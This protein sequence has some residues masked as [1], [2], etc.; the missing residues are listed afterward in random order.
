MA[1]SSVPSARNCN[2]AAYRGTSHVPAVDDDAGKEDTAIRCG[3]TVNGD[4]WRA[5]GPDFKANTMTANCRLGYNNLSSGVPREGFGKW[6]MT[7]KNLVQTHTN[8][9]LKPSRIWTRCSTV[10]YRETL[11]ASPG[12]GGGLWLSVAGRKETVISDVI[13]ITYIRTMAQ[14]EVYSGLFW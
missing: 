5:T 6:K 11:D 9:I 1:Y 3:M 7:H 12:R 2:Y 4:W 8:S 14:Y 13:L 10:K